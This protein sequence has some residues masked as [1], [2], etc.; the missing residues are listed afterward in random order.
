MADAPSSSSGKAGSPTLIIAGPTGSGKS[1]LALGLAEA[2]GG[3]V[4]NADSM[5]VYRDA[6]LLTARPTAA[7]EARVPHRL[8]GMLAASDPCS[9][10]RWRAL[11]DAEC[12]A[13]ERAGRPALVVGGTGLY[14]EAMLK[15]LAPVPPVPEAVRREAA[16]LFETLGGERFRAL[17]IERDPRAAGL[18]PR[19]R[20]RLLRAWEVLSATGRPLA[21]WQA[22]AAHPPERAF[23]IVL[24]SPPREILYPALDARF[25]RMLAAGGL[26]EAWAL[27]RRDLDPDLPL[28]KAVGIRQLLT[29]CAG[30]ISLDAAT[31]AAQ[32][33][34]RNYA[35]RQMT[36]VRHRLVADL[37]VREKF[38][39]RI[40]AEMFPIIRRQLLTGCR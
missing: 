22:Q 34:T 8:F 39:E 40:A 30:A 2:L 20:Q 17:L 15:G 31:A 10:G 18:A 28:L 16:R 13:A 38:S 6:R 36:W 29:H 5:Q 1:A 27:H 19:D 33:A 25:E 9:A 35:K 7:D 37:C 4:I 24:L 26:D 14:L 3:T 32:Q 12:A 21:H 23:F 11:A